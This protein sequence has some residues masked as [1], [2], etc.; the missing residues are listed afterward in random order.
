MSVA[1]RLE[2][3]RQRTRRRWGVTVAVVLLGLLVATIHW[4]GF[5]LGGALVALPQRTR[6]RGV[7]AGLGFG[8]AAWAVFLVILVLNGTAAPYLAMGEVFSLSLAI[9]I[10]AAFLGSLLRLAE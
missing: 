8:V 7:L 10:V 3:L 6:T 9:P 1:D 2:A 5:L 4:L